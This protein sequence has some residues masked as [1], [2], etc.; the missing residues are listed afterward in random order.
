[1]MKILSLTTSKERPILAKDLRG[2]LQRIYRS[3]QLML[4]LVSLEAFSLLETS[5]IV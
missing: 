3:P 2:C 5:H 1:L 4:L